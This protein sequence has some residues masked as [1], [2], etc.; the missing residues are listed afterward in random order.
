MKRYIMAFVTTVTICTTAWAQPRISFNEEVHNFGTISWKRPVTHEFTVTNLGD[1]PLV[2]T[3]VTV[4]CGC[5]VTDWTKEPIPAGGKGSV[6]VTY[7]AKMLGRFEKS[8]AIYSNAEPNLKYL[9]FKGEVVP[10]ARNYRVS[11]PFVIGTVRVNNTLLEFP[12]SRRG[13]KPQVVLEVV[14]TTRSPFR[15]ALMHLPPWIKAEV[16]PLVVNHEERGTI[17]LTLDTEK[18]KDIGLAQPSVYLSRFPGDKVSK[19]N[20]IV[21][22]AVILPRELE[23]TVNPPVLQLSVRELDFSHKLTK[24]KVSEKVL[25]TNTGSSPLEI[26]KLQVFNPALAVSLPKRVIKP[27]ESVKL[28]VTFNQRNL[29]DVI[30]K[31][32]ILMITNDPA[33][34]KVEL[35]V[36]LTNE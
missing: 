1:Q 19:E 31:L 23:N 13:E 34:P 11:H 3:N 35:D 32:S 25:I 2:L 17:T 8:V 10:E 20:E 33:R 16:D 15:P 21:L 24:D 9:T 5:A 12:D 7:D 6:K 36:R 28:T 18:V 27:G 30:R 4:S 29:K 22:S 26:H 14:N